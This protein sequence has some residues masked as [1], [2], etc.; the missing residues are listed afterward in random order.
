[1]AKVHS[2]GGEKLEKECM[3]EWQREIIFKQSPC[4][5]SDVRLNPL[6]HEIRT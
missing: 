2:I 3:Q 4:V 1:M 6:T 5:K